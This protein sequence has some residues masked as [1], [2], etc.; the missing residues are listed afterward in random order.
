[1][2]LAQHRPPAR[3][4]A[5]LIAAG[6]AAASLVTA[7]TAFAADPGTSDTTPTIAP[8]SPS[9]PTAPAPRTMVKPAPVLMQIG[10]VGSSVSDVQ[11]RLRLLGLWPRA[12]DGSYT[13]TL[14]TA[15]LTFQ[16]QSSTLSETGTIDRAT[17]DEL[18]RRTATPL[19]VGARSAASSITDVKVRLARLGL[20]SGTVDGTWSAAVPTA[21]LA[22]QRTYD[23]PQSA[24]VDTRT[25]AQLSAATA[26]PVVVRAG[27][28]GWTVRDVQVR[29]RML[30]TWVG[31]VDHSYTV[32]FA[33]A[34][35][36]QQSRLGLP[37]TGVVDKVTYDR[38]VAATSTP[39][40]LL[41]GASGDLVRDVQARLK[42]LG[43]WSQPVDGRYGA[44]LAAALFSFNVSRGLPTPNL[45]DQRT[46]GL[47]VTQAASPVLLRIGSTGTFVTEVERRLA[48]KG[49]WPHPADSYFGVTVST[50]LRTFQIQQG[51]PLTG[52]L[53]QRTWD[54]LR[55]VTVTPSAPRTFDSTRFNAGLDP[56]L[57]NINDLDPRCRVGR[58]MCASKVTR[59]LTWVVN[60]RPIKVMWARF[61]MPGYDT[62][63]GTFPVD[64]KYEYVVSNI[65]FVP[66]PYSMFFSGGQ[67]VHYSS[68]FA[69]LGYAS[70]SHGCINIKDYSGLAWLYS[71]VRVGDKVVVYR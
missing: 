44:T 31:T 56:L 55:A 13:T 67:A 29:M 12:A 27:Q 64:R 2:H 23:A 54:R 24:V 1:M 39:T 70:G 32:A 26:H 62:R 41:P 3:R 36:G 16:K 61:G 15:V 7:P 22:F 43:Y 48:Q 5:S 40:V 9:S 45:L 49:L 6:L 34:V 20:W 63:E 4:V 69:R 66:M 30:G 50:Q 57:P 46:W 17:W 14:A 52:V 59:T 51:L 21:I 38:I 42:V 47:I 33:R 53:D 19:A 18:T 60:G 10:S 8:T 35:R 65:Y 28:V 71:Q 68:N 25:L 37:V 58:V 11:V